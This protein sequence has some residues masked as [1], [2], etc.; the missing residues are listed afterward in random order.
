MHGRHGARKGGQGHGRR[1]D[2]R[3]R[4]RAL[5]TLHEAL[6]RGEDPER[7]AR[8]ALSV[9]R[10]CVEA[11]LLLAD[12]ATTPRDARDLVRDAVATATRVL[13]EEG[14]R[15]G[16]GRLGE[17]ADGAAYL[18]ALAA[19]A[20]HQVAE[21]R[22]EQAIQTFEGLLAMDVADPVQ[23]RG[24]LLVLLLTQDR[25]DEAED[26]LTRYPAESNADW[27]FARA[28]LRWRRAE[29][30]EEEARATQALAA[31]VARHPSAVAGGGFA[32]G[33]DATL[34]RCYEA[35]EGATAWLRGV[36]A[37]SV[38][39]GGGPPPVAADAEAD[40][41]FTAR[42]HVADA[43]SEEGAKREA[44]ARAALARWPD[45]AEAWRVLASVAP[46]AAE[47]VERLRKA[48][49]AG[50]RA[51]R[52]GSADRGPV[53]D[54]EEAFDL[55]R[56][57]AA[58]AEALRGAGREDEATAQE[59]LLLDE[60]A[61][62]VTGTA[63]PFVARA[64]EQGRDDEAGAVL[65]ARARDARPGWV[66]ARVL[67]ARRRGDSVACGFALAEAA[68]VAPLVAP[69]LLAGDLRLSEPET[70]GSAEDW[71][72]SRAAADVL[73]PAWGATPGALE[74]LATR[75][76]P[77]AARSRSAPRPK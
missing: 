73:R 62:D 2:P 21:D 36:V 51:L 38:G 16:R 71:R 10:E 31:A 44:L 22:V 23:V 64:L 37:Q 75:I 45:C 67:A 56:A 41:R 54:S 55:V 28:L 48:T 1:D 47:R 65:A 27:S 14:L 11:L 7:A 57:R 63:L 3:A 66:W 60:D 18:H 34:G 29:T 40:R 30:E 58:W 9:S 17:T 69:L 12:F 39:G 77:P 70:A 61:D 19:L 59:R 53:G 25:D 6:D 72:A 74:W 52:R 15:R 46:T 26:L 68:M 5:E 20:R 43:W 24:D 32:A 49:E 4:A 50:M 42:E 13:G 33:V 35:T 76:P 8:R